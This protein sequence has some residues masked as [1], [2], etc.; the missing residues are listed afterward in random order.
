MKPGAAFHP[1]PRKPAE[2]PLEYEVRCMHA[3]MQWRRDEAYRRTQEFMR[4]A[5]WGAVVVSCIGT[6]GLVAAVALVLT[7]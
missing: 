3:E 1:P 7:R 2:M 4:Q 5:V 6:L